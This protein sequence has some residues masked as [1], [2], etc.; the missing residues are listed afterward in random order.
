LSRSSSR[1]IVFVVRRSKL[2]P[3]SRATATSSSCAR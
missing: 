3:I 2:V 1:V